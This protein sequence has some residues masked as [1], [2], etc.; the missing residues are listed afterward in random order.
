MSSVQRLPAKSPPVPR[1]EDDR[2]HKLNRTQYLEQN[3][4]R[5]SCKQRHDAS[6]PAQ[7]EDRQQCKKGP[8]PDVQILTAPEH[9]CA[10]AHEKRCVET[11]LTVHGGIIDKAFG[12]SGWPQN[13]MHQPYQCANDAERRDKI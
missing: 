7:K 1:P 13:N 10:K 2:Q 8:S 9:G 11:V 3:V 4:W 6:Q 5:A 12:D